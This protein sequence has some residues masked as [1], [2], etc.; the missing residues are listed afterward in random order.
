M[1]PAQDPEPPERVY[2]KDRSSGRIHIRSRSPS[3]RLLSDEGCNL[4]QAGGYDV[5][6]EQEALDAPEELRCR[7]DFSEP[8]EA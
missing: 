2:T 5:I 3:G 8:E 4:D 6:T 1:P 7:N